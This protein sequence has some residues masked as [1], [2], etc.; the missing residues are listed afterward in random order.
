MVREKSAMGFAGAGGVTTPH[1][2]RLIAT[3]QP[4]IT[5]LW[6]CSTS[7]V[8]GH[9]NVWYIYYTVAEWLIVNVFLIQ[10]G[11]II[12]TL[13]PLYFDHASGYL[14]SNLKENHWSLWCLKG[15]E[16]MLASCPT[17]PSGL[18]GR[19]SHYLLPYCCVPFLAKLH[20]F[21]SLSIQHPDLYEGEKKEKKCTY[22]KVT[23][24]K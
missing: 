24:F 20:H 9:K 1:T 19:G 10:L 7:T 6:C 15:T 23:F 2:P 4:W 11:E 3:A 22:I 21:L 12:N 14:Y 13:V 8:S 17:A 18:W 16:A 5:V